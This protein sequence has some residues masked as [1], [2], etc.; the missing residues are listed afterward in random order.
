MNTK[1]PGRR[2]P[3][4]PL[5]LGAGLVVLAVLLPWVSLKLDGHTRAAQ[6][7][8]SDIKAFHSK[9]PSFRANALTEADQLLRRSEGWQ[10]I[11]ILQRIEWVSLDW[12]FG[13]AASRA[14]APH[15]ALVQVD[16]AT[17]AHLG[18]GDVI[19]RTAS[20]GVSQR[21][22]WNMPWPRMPTYGRALR[23]LRAEGAV[24]VGFDVLFQELQREE[25]RYAM[26]LEF[27]DELKRPGA[28][29]IL[30]IAPDGDPAPLF[31]L[32][33]A[34]VGGVE[35]FKDADSVYRRVRAYSDFRQLN[36]QF[37]RFAIQRAWKF[38]LSRDQQVLHLETGPQTNRVVQDI[39]VSEPG[40]VRLPTG[41]FATEWPLF[42]TNRTWQLGLVLAAYPLGLDLKR[43]GIVAQ[44]LLLRS[45]NGV[46]VRRI[47]VDGFGCFSVNWSLTLSHIHESGLMEKLEDLIQRDV[48]RTNAMGPPDRVATN[49]LAG[50]IVVIG[51][52][53]SAKS[54]SDQGATPLDSTDFLVGTH[55]NVAQQVLMDESVRRLRFR[56]VAALMA[57]LATLACWVTWNLRGVWSPLVILALGG[58]WLSTALWAFLAHR[59]ML[60]VAH[61]LVAGLL[62]PYGAMVSAR[63]V[64]EQRERHRVRSVFAKMVSPEI[65]QEMLG[66]GRIELGGARREVSVFFA[67]VRGFTD[68]TDRAQAE[69]EHY[70]QEQGIT[71]A[72]AEE[73]YEARAHDVLDTVNLYLGAIADVV[74]F[75]Q[76]TL[77]KYIGDCV[78]AFWGAPVANPRHAVCCV[79]AAIDAQRIVARLNAVRGR[80]NDRRTTE[81]RERLEKK[82]PK[83]PLLPLLALGTGV[84]SGVVTVGLMG[85]D[86]HIV[87]Y[88]VF[89]RE[90]NLAARLEGVSGY[91]RIVI[92]DS[93]FRALVQHAPALARMCRPLEPVPVKGFRAPVKV[94]EVPWQESEAVAAE[95]L[96]LYQRTPELAF[97]RPAADE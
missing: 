27:A 73:Y 22:F 48:A 28:A 54:L 39:V 69:A 83:L 47:P 95:Q 57:C 91:S 74:K 94:F 58:A 85:S 63:A 90:V 30:A 33:A 37:E 49:R 84:N 55:L 1:L 92:G 53:A 42:I 26:D 36:P 66:S 51:S 65:V 31:Q 29:A 12:R 8:S 62:L 86:A 64:F 11:D 60:P 78:M 40:T 24:A 18:D 80:E 4:L 70:V 56:W 89:G 21:E 81:N 17:I 10:R 88:T 77:D 20:D 46:V 50:R 41:R 68:L 75:H 19:R 45:T 87:N 14:Q 72:A 16:D 67:D 2:L 32:Q 7:R 79:V 3:P 25:S 23:E 44:E 82:H 76:G 34:A 6:V 96:K 38:N 15:V 35:T 61:P 59:W 13:W 52:M 9:F 93:T 71:G 5:V 43:S 97:N